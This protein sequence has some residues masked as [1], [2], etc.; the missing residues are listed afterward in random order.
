LILLFFLW[1]ANPFSSFN[2][3]SGSSVPWLAVSIHLSICQALTKPLR[4][5]L[6]QV[7]VSKHF[8]ACAIVSG[9]GNCIWDGSLGTGEN[10]MN[11]TPMS[12]A[13]RSSID[14][15]ELIKLQSF[16]KAKDTVKRT[17]RQP[18]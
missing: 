5:K 13:L 11:R 1:V 6:Y 7:P 18:T 12:Y 4:R 2:P 17:K 16:C 8:L 3:F 14:K 15:W 10:F 9:F